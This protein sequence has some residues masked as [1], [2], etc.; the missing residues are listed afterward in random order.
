[1]GVQYKITDDVGVSYV[2]M[3]C[4]GNEWI[5]LMHFYG[6]DSHRRAAA[7]IEHEKYLDNL[8]NA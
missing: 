5:K 1:M 4:V 2:W 8:D 6:N 3:L 7:W